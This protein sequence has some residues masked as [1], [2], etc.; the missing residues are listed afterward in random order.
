[1]SNLNKCKSNE[2]AACCCTD[3]GT[4]IDNDDCVAEYENVFA[5][6]ALAQ[7]KLQLLTQ[8]A[9]DIESEPCEIISQ[10]DK[11]NSGYQLA[12]KFHFCCGAECLIFQLKLR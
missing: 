3:I 4:I 5:T 12:A 6:Q 1:M 8:A 7:E 10:I 9:R 2:T 11:V